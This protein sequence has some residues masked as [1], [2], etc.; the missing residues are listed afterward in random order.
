M[1]KAS[2]IHAGYGSMTVLR[3]IDFSVEAREVVLVLGPNGAGKSTLLRTMSGLIPPSAGSITFDGEDVTRRGPERLARTG[4]RHV[5]EGHRVFPELTVKEN[6]RLGQISLESSKRRPDREIFNEAFDV[7]PV[8]GEKCDLLARSLSGG[9]QQM[10][11]LVQA[12]AGRPR[13]LMC[14]EPTMGLALALVPEI[15]TFLR[16]RADEGMGVILVEQTLDQP[17][18]IAD[19]IVMLKQG[20]VSTFGTPAEL[21]TRSDIA[22]MMMGDLST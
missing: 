9:Q 17:L 1:L 7:F 15:L 5:M 2:G 6:I 21:G 8:L 4:I 13:I 10:L 12:W 20:M 18:Q 19:R 11:A 16:R 22:L 3:D 14:D